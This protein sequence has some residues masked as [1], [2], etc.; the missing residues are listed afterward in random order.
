MHQPRRSN[1]Q[2]LNILEKRWFLSL[3]LMPYKL[4]N[5]GNNKNDQSIY[6]QFAR[7]VISNSIQSINTPQHQKTNHYKTDQHDRRKPGI[8]NPCKK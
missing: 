1:Q 2:E 8:I 3:D 4:A 5:P 6:C 7:I